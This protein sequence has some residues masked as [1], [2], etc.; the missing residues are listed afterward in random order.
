MRRKIKRKNY[1]SECQLGN[2]E[3]EGGECAYYVLIFYKNHNFL[4]FLLFFSIYLDISITF[5]RQ[6]HTL[7]ISEEVISR[8]PS[9][10]IR[11]H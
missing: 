10:L 4:L 11:L 5:F 7:N 2:I 3:R 9:N 1:G 8:R 6:Y